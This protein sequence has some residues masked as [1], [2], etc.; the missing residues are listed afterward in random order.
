MSN[1]EQ[2]SLI[3]KDDSIVNY[4]EEPGYKTEVLSSKLGITKRRLELWDTSGLLVPSIRKG[5]GSGISKL[6]SFQDIVKAKLIKSMLDLG[7]NIQKIKEIVLSLKND[8]GVDNFAGTTLL[9]DG[10]KVYYCTSKNEIVD[11]LSANKQ[12]VLAI[13]LANIYEAVEQ[14]KETVEYAPQ[15]TLKKAI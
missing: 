5:C 9:T 7:V 4:N 13:D 2:L 1:Y 3:S 11:I 14:Y 10:E 15:L 8:F 6:Y 12:G